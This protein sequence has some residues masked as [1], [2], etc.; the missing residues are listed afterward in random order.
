MKDT[1]Q[2]KEAE[3]RMLPGSIT[4]QGFLGEDKRHVAEIVEADEGEFRRLGLVFEIVAAEL[5]RLRDQG[6]RGLGEPVTVDGTWLVQTGDARGKLA[7]PYEDGIH[8]K[9]SVWLKRVDSGEALV[10]TDLSIHLL[11]EH[12]FL[13]GRGS[14][15]RLEPE[16][17]KRVLGL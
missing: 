4:A 8:H 12:H 17:L 7:C 2:H 11:R 9:N 1:I 5:E 6:E 3:A 13:Q 15:F 14:G 10:Y 16:A